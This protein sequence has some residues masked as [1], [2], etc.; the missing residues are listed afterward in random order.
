MENRIKLK[1]GFQRNLIERTKKI[2]KLTWNELSK[3]LGVSGNYLRIDLRYEN[4]LLSERIYKDL[5]KLSGL[6][7]DKYIIKK[8]DKNWGRSKGGKL[9]KPKERRAKILVKKH[10]IRLAEIMGIMLGDG[11]LWERR[12]FYYT[13]ICGHKVDDREYLLSHVKPLFKRVFNIDMKLYYHKTTKEAYLTKGSKDLVFTLKYFGLKSGNKIANEVGVPAW[14]F[15]SKKYI[16]ACV[17]GLI[18]TDGTVLP[19]TGR[20]YTYIWFTCG[21]PTLRGD[22][23]KAMKILGYKIAKWNFSRTPET[24]IGSKELIRKYYKEIGFNNPKHLKRFRAPVV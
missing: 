5:C 7:Y 23:E 6:D 4:I 13:R 20:N 2:K 16:K 3:Q 10:S 17:R 1:T 11:N 8:L 24:Y 12:G 18:D 15:K 9:S 14:I 21:N 22:F 19:I